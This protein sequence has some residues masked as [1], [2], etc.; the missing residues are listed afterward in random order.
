MPPRGPG[1]LSPDTVQSPI[2]DSGGVL[3]S[4]ACEPHN[5]GDHTWTILIHIETGATDVCYHDAAEMGFDQSRWYMAQGSSEMR[6]GG[7]PSGE[8]WKALAARLWGSIRGGMSR[9][10]ALVSRWSHRYN[11]AFR[12]ARLINGHAV[13]APKLQP[14]QAENGGFPPPPHGEQNAQ[15]EDQERRQEA[16]QGDRDRQG[17]CT[18][19]AASATA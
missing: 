7:C 14:D 6:P 16:I 4:Q 2:F 19:S 11:P 10:S 5:C 17:A 13:A 18:P 3:L 8:R 1:S 12:A 9:D 15:D